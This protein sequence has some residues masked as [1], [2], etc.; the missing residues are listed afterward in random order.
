MGSAE[1]QPASRHGFEEVKGDW[2][3]SGRNQISYIWHF[4]D[5]LVKQ[6]GSQAHAIIR[7]CR[8]EVS[9]VLLQF[10]ALHATAH[11]SSY[12]CITT[13]IILS[14]PTT[15]PCHQARCRDRVL[16]RLQLKL[17]TSKLWSTDSSLPHSEQ[18]PSCSDGGSCC[19]LC[20]GAPVTPRC[21]LCQSQ[22]QL[23]SQP[24]SLVLL[25][26]HT[27]SLVKDTPGPWQSLCAPLLAGLSLPAHPGPFSHTSGSPL[28][29]VHNIPGS[30][31]C[32]VNWLY[33]AFF[34]ISVFES[35]LWDIHTDL[36]RHWLLKDLHY[37]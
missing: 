12:H 32:S 10:F 3:R 5:F 13:Y 29:N 4:I 20:P 34:C 1:S 19:T 37:P 21:S 28:E 30:L 7:Y 2:K 8:N 17:T 23:V 24:I 33:S 16:I 14:Y 31:C 36:H 22:V 25:L 11:L 6:P 35:T 15:Q 18:G 26:P 9:E 27:G